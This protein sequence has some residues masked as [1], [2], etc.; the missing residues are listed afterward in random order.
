[1]LRGRYR[2]LFFAAEAADITLAAAKREHDRLDA[3][4]RDDTSVAQKTVLQAEA[5]WRTAEAER[6]RLW[7]ELD[8]LRLAARLEWGPVLAELALAA[9]DP[10]FAR[11]ASGKDSLLRAVLPP[12]RMLPSAAAEASFAHNG[13]AVV[14]HHLAPA[15][16]TLAGGGESHFFI[17][18]LP[19]PAALRVHMDVPAVAEPL[20]G[21][22]LPPGAVVRALGRD[23]V[24]AQVD[25]SHFVRREVSLG[26]VLPDGRYLSGGLESDDNVA[27]IG[28]MVLYAEEFRSQIRN[29]DDD[30]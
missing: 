4:Y 28:A 19:L 21:L 20:Q 23:W 27:I 10:G 3:L 18:P 7:T 24:Y 15:P 16:R 2:A 25:E 9:D 26:P 5:E 29:E 14:A 17:A 12:G 1:M 8:S 11:L 22:A 6:Y 13:G 30:D